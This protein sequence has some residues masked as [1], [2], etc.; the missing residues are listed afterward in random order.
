MPEP[1]PQKIFPQGIFLEQPNENAPSYIKGR[2]SIKLPEATQ[3]LEQHQNNA[4]Y[5]NLTLRESLANTLYLELDQWKPKTETPNQNLN[6][7]NEPGPVPLNGVEYPEEVNQ[8]E[9]I[10]F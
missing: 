10:P 9:D 3:W 5:V 2:I 1:K 6:T 7:A 8:A 4:G